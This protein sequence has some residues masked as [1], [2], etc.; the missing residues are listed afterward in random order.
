MRERP[1]QNLTH[2]PLCNMMVKCVSQCVG[3]QLTL[4]QTISRHKYR[5]V[6]HTSTHLLQTA[7]EVK[8]KLGSPY[9]NNDKIR[10]TK[11]TC[12][13]RDMAAQR[14]AGLNLKQMSVHGRTKRW[15]DKQTSHG[16][17]L[18]P[19]LWERSSCNLSILQSHLNQDDTK[20]SE[21]RNKRKAKT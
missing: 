21:H 16:D 11:D 1:Y 4:L 20:K 8:G 3:P 13:N 18:R 5:T 7:K 15:V 17:T 2:S 19:Y 6:W 14:H 10:R 12:K 9:G